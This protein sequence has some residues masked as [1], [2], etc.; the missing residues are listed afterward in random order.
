MGFSCFLQGSDTLTV[1][2]GAML[3][4]AGHEIRAVITADAQVADWAG[5]EG[6]TVAETGAAVSGN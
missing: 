3:L 1:Q 5:S 6:L 2:C 4:A